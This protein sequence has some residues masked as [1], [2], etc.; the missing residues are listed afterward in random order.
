MGYEI[1]GE[2]SAR[3]KSFSS[4]LL[5]ICFDGREIFQ[6]EVSI[7]DACFRSQ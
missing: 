3:E 4:S 7:S 5:K 1:D 6:F 2:M